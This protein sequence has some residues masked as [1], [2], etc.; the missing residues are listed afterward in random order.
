MQAVMYDQFG[1][2]SVL[3]LRETPTPQPA[4]GEVQVRVRMASLNPDF[5]TAE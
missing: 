2:E 3:S 4:R 5:D 1:D